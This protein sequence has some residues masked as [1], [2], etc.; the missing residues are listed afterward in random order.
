M[1][2]AQGTQQSLVTAKSHLAK[3]GLTIPRQ[4]LVSTHMTANLISNVKE[5]LAG[6]PVEGVYG[7]LDSSIALHWIKGNGDYWQFVA[8]R[9]KKIQ[10]NSFIQW[11]YVHSD[12]N[13][14]DLGSR[15][16]GVDESAKLWQEGPAWLAEPGSWPPDIV[17]AA[18]SETQAEAKVVREALFVTKT[19]DCVLNETLE[20]HGYW[21]A[22]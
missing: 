5:A 17:T 2:Q 10:H 19:E 6:F 7:W 8:S 12:Q 13:P 16:G 21:K 14:A 11:R 22:F 4:E 15:G 20:K 9:V 1:R 3:Q 18:T